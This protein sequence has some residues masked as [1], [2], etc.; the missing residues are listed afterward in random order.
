MD[1]LRKQALQISIINLLNQNL[2]DVNESSVK[3][4]Y[5]WAF[6]SS[7]KNET[8]SDKKSLNSNFAIHQSHNSED[9]D[10]QSKES[11]KN[12]NPFDSSAVNILNCAF[13][14]N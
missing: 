14:L 7:L 4:L 3:L 5:Q 12:P 9:E 6:K 13:I 2:I 11:H 10:V 8:P 1:D